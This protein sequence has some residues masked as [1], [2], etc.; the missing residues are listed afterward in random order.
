MEYRR[1]WAKNKGNMDFQAKNVVEN[2]RKRGTLFQT[3][4]R[5]IGRELLSKA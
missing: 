1:Y 4:G 3:G 5:C 2:I